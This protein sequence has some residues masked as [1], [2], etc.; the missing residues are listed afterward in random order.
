MTLAMYPSGRNFVVTG[1]PKLH[2]WLINLFWKI[3][4]RKHNLPFK[5]RS[6]QATSLRISYKMTVN[7]CRIVN[8]LGPPRSGDIERVSMHTQAPSPKHRDTVSLGFGAWKATSMLLLSVKEAAFTHRQ[9]ASV[10][11]RTR[12]SLY[13]RCSPE[14][15]VVP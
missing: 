11:R 7:I 15:G 12:G 2:G 6:P 14:D 1:V 9:T 4:G 8:I 3:A 13:Y 5:F 10:C